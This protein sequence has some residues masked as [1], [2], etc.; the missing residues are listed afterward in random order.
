MGD[1][2]CFV[3]NEEEEERRDWEY[4]GPPP[5]PPGV[6][7]CAGTTC[8]AITENP[9]IHTRIYIYSESPSALPF[10]DAFSIRSPAYSYT[11]P[12]ITEIQKN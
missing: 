8:I 3:L 4:L 9:Y 2:V 5:S 12:S 7:N 10:F 11:L 1:D 6:V